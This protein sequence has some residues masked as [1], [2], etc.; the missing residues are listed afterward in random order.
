MAGMDSGFAVYAPHPVERHAPVAVVVA[1]ATGDDVPV[2]AV[3]QARA[4]GGSAGEWADRI[5]RA[6]RGERSLVVAAK[7]S[8]E[9]VGYANVA[10]LPEHPVDR[11]PA[12]Y[13]LTGVTVDPAWRRRGIARLL[14]RRRM[15]WVWE[16][17]SAIRC[18]VSVRNPA[19]LDLHRELGF[20]HERT[21]A[22]F[23]GIEFAGGEGRL[24][25]AD[26]PRS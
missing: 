17:D 4:R 3:L 21:G 18:F 26:P 5:H 2:L 11:A 12:G 1:E 6:R 19:S 16:R 15:D 22:S 20:G 10:F 9:A 8:G 25:R 14:T 7:V 13:Y 23:Q 24:L